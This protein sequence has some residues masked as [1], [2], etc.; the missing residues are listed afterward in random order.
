MSA[1]EMLWAAGL[2]I[3]AGLTDGEM[4][5]IREAIMTLT[6]RRL[7]AEEAM[8][9]IDGLVARLRAERAESEGYAT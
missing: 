8:A 5:A 2:R 7:T 4:A 9:E 6:A 3:P 1:L